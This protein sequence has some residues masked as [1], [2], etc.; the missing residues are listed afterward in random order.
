MKFL[1][2]PKMFPLKPRRKLHAA[3]AARRSVAPPMDDYDEEPQTKLS[4][5][6]IVVLV[7][8][9]VAVGGIYAFKSIKAQRLAQEPVSNT[10]T[11]PVKP[12][13]SSVPPVKPL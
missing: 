1:K 13:P 9:L 10:P 11:T 7:L 4:S 5:A 12:V 6:F 2:L 8:H 3:T